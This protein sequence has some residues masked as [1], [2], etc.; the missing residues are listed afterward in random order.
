MRASILYLAITALLFA[1]CSGQ[2]KYPDYSH[3]SGFDREQVDSTTL[4]NLTVLGRVWGYVKYHHPVFA[5]STLN[6]DYELF[7]L[8]PQVADVAPE[9]RNRILSEWID[10]LGEFSVARE[11]YDSLPPDVIGRQR[12]D[13]GWT[14]DTLRLG[15]ELSDRLARLR[16]ADRERN[17]YVTRT[18][19]N[20]AYYKK[21]LGIDYNFKEWVCENPGFENELS[22]PE[23][24]ELDYGYR[25]LSVFRFWNAVVY[26]FPSKYLIER[27]WKDVLP[28]YIARMATLPDSSYQHTMWRMIAEIKD[29]HA[30]GRLN[31]SQLFGLFY[32]P[33]TLD[34]VEDRL[35]VSAPDTL[36]IA[37]ERT[38]PFR[39]GDEVLAVDG[40]P[41]A[42]YVD[43][44]REYIPASNEERVYAN[45]ARTI[46]YTPLN[47]R[48][49]IRYHRKGG[50][51]DTLVGIS[52]YP[53]PFIKGGA[54]RMLE[55]TRIFYLNPADYTKADE[56]RLAQMLS[57]S[58]GFIIDLRNIVA[59]EYNDFVRK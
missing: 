42:Y 28:E 45:A 43:R 19:Y 27:P 6:V 5:D 35:I 1:A 25:L 20:A 37:E 9:T 59:D 29:S 2:K 31:P 39:V 33:V 34:F 15:T 14:Q 10:D 22:Y 18:H 40:R 23:V 58:E 51:R 54:S 57:G 36:P 7:E 49:R 16:Y 41:V 46:R 50:E 3:G 38:S 24:K 12:I 47:T 26:F 53:K 56:V 32:A 55:N 44:A 30:A 21:N 4:E 8:L 48:L 13:V 52:A 17:Y 11:K